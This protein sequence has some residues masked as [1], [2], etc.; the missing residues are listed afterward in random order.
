MGAQHS[1]LEIK[2]YSPCRPIPASDYTGRAHQVALNEKHAKIICW[3]SL[4]TNLGIKISQPNHMHTYVIQ[5]YMQFGFC[6]Y[7]PVPKKENEVN[8]KHVSFSTKNI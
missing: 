1:G 5:W 8:S 7:P 3:G 6:S 2:Q 4:H